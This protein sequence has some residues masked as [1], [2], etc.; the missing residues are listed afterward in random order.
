MPSE[1]KQF[2]DRIHIE[3]LELTARIGVPEKER[4]ASQ[5]LTASRSLASTG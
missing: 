4:A 1:T 3:Q 2:F 5:R